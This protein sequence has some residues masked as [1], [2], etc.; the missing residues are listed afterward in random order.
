MDKLQIIGGALT[1]IAANIMLILV[2]SATIQHVQSGA[3]GTIKDENNMLYLGLSILAVIGG[4]LGI[5]DRKSGGIMALLSGSL[6]TFFGIIYIIN[7]IE[8]AMFAPFTLLGGLVTLIPLEAILI[9]IGAILLL[10]AK[11]E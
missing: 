8:Y 5:A 2:I 11:S 7:P 10:K 9:F 3:W 6:S 4:G 1:L